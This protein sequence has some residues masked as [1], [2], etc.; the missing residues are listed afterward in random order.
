MVL[1]SLDPSMF[2]AKRYNFKKQFFY[3]K[4]VNLFRIKEVYLFFLHLN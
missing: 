4:R 2:M 3:L 1:D